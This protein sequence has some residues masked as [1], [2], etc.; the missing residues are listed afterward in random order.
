MW[1]FDLG[2]WM[3]DFGCMKVGFLLGR[4]WIDVVWTFGI[5]L[6]GCCIV[7]GERWSLVG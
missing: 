7:I 2:W 3:I 5:W 4:C 1:T 6:C